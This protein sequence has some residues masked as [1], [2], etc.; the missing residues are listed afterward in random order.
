MVLN[1][2]IGDECVYSLMEVYEN[3]LTDLQKLFLQNPIIINL[4]DIGIIPKLG[5]GWDGNAFAEIDN[6]DYQSFVNETDRTYFAFVLEN[7][8]VEILNYNTPREIAIMSSNPV[9]RLEDYPGTSKHF[10]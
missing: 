4:E 1:V 3:N 7:K 2:Y 6:E 9:V 10:K 8:V 5:S